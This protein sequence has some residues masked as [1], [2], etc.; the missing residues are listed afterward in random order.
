MAKA[1]LPADPEVF[2]AEFESL[3]A[4]AMAKKYNCDVRTVHTRRRNVEG[5]LG[6]PLYVP[7][8]LDR[9]GRPRPTI[10]QS[11]TVK[12][13]LTLLIGSDAHYE[14][15]T[16]TTAH[17]AFVEL[18]R[19]LQPDVIVMNGD[20]LD[21]SSI[22]RHAPLGWEERPTVEQE[23]N[24]VRQRLT[25][26][27]KAA[28]SADRFWTMG[29]HDARF[30]MRLADLLP[31]FKGVQGFTLKDH[32][33]AWKFCVSLWI[34]GA[35]RPIV[36]KHRYNGGI[37]A[38]YNNALKSGVTMC[39]GHTHAMECKSWTDYTGHRYGIQ[40]GTMADPNQTTFDYAED[41]PKNW[42]SGFVVLNIRDNFLLMP[43]FV[44]VHKA[45]QYEWRGEIHKVDYP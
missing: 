30:D 40:C 15:N 11:I 22:S 44:K 39:T 26:I 8:H 36:V 10:R 14:I 25:E 9:S 1:K 3:G 43:E 32:F 13:D 33:A 45:G 5:N 21:G 38:G 20:L 37:H 31:Q 35:E 16:V 34:D 12:K 19:K 2:G 18:A 24:A 41:G 6:R 28:P 29:N 23:L 17:L 27:E 42:V 7:A 4:S